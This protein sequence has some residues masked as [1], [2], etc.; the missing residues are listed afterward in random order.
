MHAAL[1][2]DV[3][4]TNGNPAPAEWIVYTSYLP[5]Y[6]CTPLGTFHPAES[7]VYTSVYTCT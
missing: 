1:N 6:T 2:I 4:T 3:Y 5:V 7:I